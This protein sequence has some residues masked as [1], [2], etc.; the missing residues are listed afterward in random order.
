MRTS[1]RVLLSIT[2]QQHVVQYLKMTEELFLQRS[3]N[4]KGHSGTV[5]DALTGLGT[6]NQGSKLLVSTSKKWWRTR[7]FT[8]GHRDIQNTQYI[9]VLDD[10]IAQE[11]YKAGLFHSVQRCSDVENCAADSRKSTCPWVM[12]L[13]KRD[14]GDIAEQCPQS[15]CSR[16]VPEDQ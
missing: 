1:F 3:W 7:R 14:N 16:L 6:W 4:G 2:L 8:D 10:L 15:Y 13:T 12:G 11:R 9:T 5:Y